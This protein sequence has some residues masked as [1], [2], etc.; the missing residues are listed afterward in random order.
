MIT[1]KELKRIINY[2]PSTGIF[3]WKISP[4]YNINMGDIAGSI[5]GK[6]YV[7]LKI[8]GSIYSGHRLA[9]FYMLGCWPT[10]IDHRNCCK[11]DNR[12]VNLRDVPHKENMQNRHS[13]PAN[14]TTGALGVHVSRDKFVARIKVDGRT[15][16]I[17]VYNT[18]R[19]ASAAFINVKRALHPGNTL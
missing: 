9:W 16:H 1:Q 19:E 14:S 11:T 10:E 13:A 2:D 18:I 12:Y 17:G 7:R 6:G 15:R 5:D 4:R 8:S 3:T